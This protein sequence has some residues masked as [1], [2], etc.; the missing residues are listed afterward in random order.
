M[1]PE[2]GKMKSATATAKKKFGKNGGFP[3]KKKE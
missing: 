1:A 2:D 3:K